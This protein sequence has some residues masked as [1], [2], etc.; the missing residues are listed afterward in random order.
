MS[1]WIQ[2]VEKVVADARASFASTQTSAPPVIPSIPPPPRSTGHHRTRSR[3]VPRANEIFARGPPSPKDKDTS[4][5]STKPGTPTRQSFTK[6]SPSP[7]PSPSKR[8]FNFKPPTPTKGMFRPSSK[9][10]DEIAERS[11]EDD[12]PMSLRRKTMGAGGVASVE[13][14]FGSMNKSARSRMESFENMRREMMKDLGGPPAAL[15]ASSSPEPD[16]DDAAP[17]RD[18]DGPIRPQPSMRLTAMM[19]AADRTKSPSPSPEADAALA[20]LLAEAPGAVRLV[21]AGLSNNPVPTK[22][23]RK[24]SKGRNGSK[25]FTNTHKGI[26][27]PSIDG[28]GLSSVDVQSKRVGLGGVGAPDSTFASEEFALVDRTMNMNAGD[29]YGTT[30]SNNSKEGTIVR[31]AFKALNNIGGTMSCC[32]SFALCFPVRRCKC[33]PL[34]RS[35]ATRVHS[36][37]LPLP[38]CVY[39]ASPQSCRSSSLSPYCHTIFVVRFPMPCPTTHPLPI[40]TKSVQNPTNIA[41]C[42]IHSKISSAF[43]HFIYPAC[44]YLQP[45][46]SVLRI[47]PS[48]C[49]SL[50][51]SH[52]SSW[53]SPLPYLFAI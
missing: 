32:V 33:R 41:L 24:L 5:T 14:S 52:H 53:I 28:R 49:L 18:P 48:S 37:V 47:V 19:E 50:Q 25:F 9:Y 29:Q 23:S 13:R 2:N 4:P 31:R 7:S 42:H 10:L 30:K 43:Y 36:L 45:L 39:N 27:H 22:H 8:S 16:Q 6:G 51:P 11:R 21:G 26:V 15:P 40:P 35:P 1:L 12:S 3:Q 34:V 46:S 44:I 38:C 17:Q 20:R